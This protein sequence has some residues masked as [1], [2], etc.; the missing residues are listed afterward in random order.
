MKRTMK[1]IGIALLP[2]T[3]IPIILFFVQTYC[4][5]HSFLKEQN[6]DIRADNGFIRCNYELLEPEF[7]YLFST[8]NGAQMGFYKSERLFYQTEK[9][10]DFNR[11]GGTTVKN[12]TF[13]ELVKMVKKDCSQFQEDFDA[14]DPE[15]QIDWGYREA[16]PPEPPKTQEE[17][18][19][20]EIIEK[21]NNARRVLTF[22][23]E[24]LTNLQ[25]DK[26]IEFY[27]D[28]N[29]MTTD[30][31]YQVYLQLMVSGQMMVDE[32]L[33]EYFYNEYGLKYMEYK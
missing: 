19:E 4:L 33:H 10:W 32:S 15:T 14:E 30:E 27:G 25:R 13:P 16:D 31:I 1:I 6:T 28:I 8:G 17:L 22:V 26:F 23:N 3:T 29:S 24:S 9:E 2:L 18:A 21:H 7:V 12:T 20:E 5:T 11:T